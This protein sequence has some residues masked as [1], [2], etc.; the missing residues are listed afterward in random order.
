M[1]QLAHQVP[2]RHCEGQFISHGTFFAQEAPLDQA[3]IAV[4]LHRFPAAGALVQDGVQTAQ[5][6][7]LQQ[8]AVGDQPPVPFPQQPERFQEK[9]EHFLLGFSFPQEI[10]R[11]LPYDGPVG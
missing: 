2:G 10:F 5:G 1:E 8:G 7:E 6:Q 11:R 4:F 9:L 3:E